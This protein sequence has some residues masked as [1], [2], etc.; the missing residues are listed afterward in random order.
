M[1][2]NQNSIL[3]I[4]IPTYQRSSTILNSVELL[5]PLC[6]KMNVQIV[7]IDNGS[8]DNTYITLLKKEK[9]FPNIKIVKYKENMGFKESFVRIFDNIHTK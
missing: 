3:T 2:K 7:I 6:K 5:I 8:T 1:Q 4:A 9:A